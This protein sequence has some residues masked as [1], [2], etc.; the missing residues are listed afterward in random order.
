MSIVGELF[1]LSEADKKYG[2]VV[3]F[4]PIE[5]S[6]IKGLFAKTK[7]Y[8]MFSIVNNK[9]SILGDNRVPLYPDGL[10][11]D[12]EIVFYLASVEKIQELLDSD[13]ENSVSVELRAEKL[14]ISTTT[15]TLEEIWP[16]PPYCN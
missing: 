2:K 7:N 5:K 13:S 1:T 3:Q 8:L 15:Y 11:I 4:F 9:V 12:N 14:T 16:C 10:K 6:I